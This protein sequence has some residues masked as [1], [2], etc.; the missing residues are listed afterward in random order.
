V[1]E[2]GPAQTKVAMGLEG[3]LG[4][5]LTT[6]RGG[7]ARPRLGTC[8]QPL[9]NRA[10][11]LATDIQ[12][13]RI[14]GGGSD[15]ATQGTPLLTPGRPTFTAPPPT[16]IRVVAFARVKNLRTILGLLAES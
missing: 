12:P 16:V 14:P 7:G 6:E 2:Q 1:V 9:E 5:P 15:V 11:V 13:P 10:T 4:H 8:L 3:S